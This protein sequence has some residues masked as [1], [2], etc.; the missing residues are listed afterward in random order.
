MRIKNK[1][2][3]AANWKMNK[4]L[5]EAIAYGDW[6]S[7]QTFNVSIEV[8][9]HVPYLYLPSLRSILNN[10]PIQIGA[11]N[12]SNFEKGAYT[13]EISA[14]ML[15]SSGTKYVLVG[16]SERRLYFNETNEII[17]QKI[18]QALKYGLHVIFC[19]GESMEQRTSGATESIILTQLNETLGTLS[20]TEANSISI[21]YEPIWAI[22][23]GLTATSHQA[24]EVHSFIR[25][26]LD[27]FF[28][29]AIAQKTA[30]LYGGSC[31]PSNANELFNVPDI[32][33]G[34]IGGASLLENDFYQ[35]IKIAEGCINHA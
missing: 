5:D 12:C 13:G 15:A 33:G 2:I 26:W 6:L 19:C 7:K 25:N 30:I 11:Q 9:L 28:G 29:S 14:A 34:L 10:S 22:G 20:D 32:D 8:I 3:V 17:L 4:S 27:G 1:L 31:N 18:R 21:A 35:L 24:Q 16:H 23:T